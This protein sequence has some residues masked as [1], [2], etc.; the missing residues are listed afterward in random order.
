MFSKLVS[1][2][3]H[4]I[5]LCDSAPLR[6]RDHVA[7]HVL[8]TDQVFVK[9]EELSKFHLFH[10]FYS[11][12]LCFLISRIA[13]ILKIGLLALPSKVCPIPYNTS[14]ICLILDLLWYKSVGSINIARGLVVRYRRFRAWYRGFY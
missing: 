1:I 10:L 11:F 13:L 9:I 12:H 4:A 2:R 8:R 14:H 7:L 6:K 5:P 3:S